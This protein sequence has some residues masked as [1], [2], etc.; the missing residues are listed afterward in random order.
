MV[1]GGRSGV[2][3]VGRTGIRPA[4]VRYG[5]IPNERQGPVPADQGRYGREVSE[6]RRRSAQ[7]ADHAGARLQSATE[8]PAEQ[9]GDADQTVHISAESALASAYADVDGD[10]AVCLESRLADVGQFGDAVAGAVRRQSV[11]LAQP[12]DRRESDPG[13]Q[14]RLGRGQHSPGVEWQQQPAGHP[15]RLDGAEAQRG[16]RQGSAEPDVTAP[17]DAA[18]ARCLPLDCQRDQRVLP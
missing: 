17:T 6:R 5:R 14:E 16:Q 8:M 2:P 18:D 10:A 3:A 7:R 15:D 9:S 12:R 1:A 4:A 13:L 11:G